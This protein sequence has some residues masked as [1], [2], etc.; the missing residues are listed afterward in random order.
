MKKS[1]KNDILIIGDNMKRGPKR[2][3]RYRS[4]I[5]PS[6][7]FGLMLTAFN[8]IFLII[9]LY[10]SV[11]TGIFVQLFDSVILNVIVNSIFQVCLFSL[12]FF[13]ISYLFIEVIINKHN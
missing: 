7:L 1:I 9:S 12:S 11:C 10:S 4:Y 5:H 13:I 8:Y 2:K 6:I 3:P